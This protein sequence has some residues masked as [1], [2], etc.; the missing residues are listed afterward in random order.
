MWQRVKKGGLSCPDLNVSKPA[1]FF[2]MLESEPPPPPLAI[3][4]CNI[5]VVVDKMHMSL[6][7]LHAY[8][9][10]YLEKK[11]YGRDIDLL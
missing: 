2:H 1:C 5:Y 9:Y 10:T 11:L 4:Q 6:K 3:S 8:T 7:D